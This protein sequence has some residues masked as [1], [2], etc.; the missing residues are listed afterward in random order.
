MFFWSSFLSAMVR[1]CGPLRLQTVRLSFGGLQGLL[2][3]GMTT[4]SL[5]AGS[6]GTPSADDGTPAGKLALPTLAVQQPAGNLPM[7]PRT[8]MLTPR[9]L[10]LSGAAK[11]SRCAA[12]ANGSCSCGTA[13]MSP[14]IAVLCWKVCTHVNMY[15]EQLSTAFMLFHCILK[16]GLGASMVPGIYF[17]RMLC[18][19]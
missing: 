19:C 13:N 8:A 15:M 16:H 5:P 18:D 4:L 9:R 7:T 6:A 14:N 17:Q 10:G 2:S 12:S 3:L 1:Q 11:V